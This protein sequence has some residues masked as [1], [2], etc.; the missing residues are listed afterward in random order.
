VVETLGNVAGHDISAVHLGCS[1]PAQP[2]RLRVL[3]T[4]GVHGNEN[5]GPGAAVALLDQLLTRLSLRQG[6]SVTVVP[7]L[8]PTGFVLGTREN[9]DG[10]DLNRRCLDGDGA[11]LE[12]RILR[13][14]LD[15]E[16]FDL[17]VDLHSAGGRC[18]GFFA[19]HLDSQTLLEEAMVRLARRFPVEGDDD[20]PYHYPAPGVFVSD[21]RG[22]LKDATKAAGA[23]WSVTV[24]AP[25][26]LPYPEQ[27]AGT[28]ALVKEL[29]AGAKK[30]MV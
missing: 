2:P 15:R 18:Y 17:A 6:V 11:P 27:V 10:I 8:N 23:K 7:C 29:I 28:A 26:A 12:V 24:E 25:R 22:T 5:V 9:A 30:S 1:D 21:N 14:L 20:G 16:D 4:A 19:L 3:I 13:R